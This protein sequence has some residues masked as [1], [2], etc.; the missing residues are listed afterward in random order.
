MYIY[1]LTLLIYDS[2]SV[3]GML[4]KGPG[5]NVSIDIK[6]TGGDQ[7]NN[8]TQRDIFSIFLPS[9]VCSF[10]LLP[11]LCFQIKTYV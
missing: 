4:A 3:G 1:I 8:A 2:F 11:F 6:G 9:F 5:V 10:Y 7:S